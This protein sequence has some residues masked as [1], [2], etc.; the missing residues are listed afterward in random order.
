MKFK[1]YLAS[2]F[3]TFTILLIILLVL[4]IYPFGNKTLIVSDLRDQYMV[5]IDYIK[6][7][8][9]GNTLFYTFNSSLG[10]NFFLLSAYYLI[11]IFNLLTIF[12]DS[13]NMPLII[14]FIILI[15][16]SLSSVTMLYYLNNKFGNKKINYLFA[17][18]YGLMSYN[19]AFY[20]H[21]MWLDS[22][23]ILP[24]IILGI[25]KIFN[26]KSVGL[27]II[28]LSMAIISNYYIGVILCIFSVI[29]FIYYYFINI[30]N[31]KNVKKVIIKYILSS[32]IS[33]LMCAVI[34]L[35][36]FCSLSSS[37]AIVNDGSIVIS[38]PYSIFEVL[39]KFINSPFTVSQIWHG[40]PNIFTG[41]L[42]TVLSILYFM[43]NKIDKRKRIINFILVLFILLTFSIRPLDLVFHGLTE[44]N[45]FDYRHAFILS[46]ILIIIGYES[47]EKI[48][49][50]NRKN[51]V[52]A[53]ILLL[54]HIITYFMDYSW[55]TG[56]R[57]LF[58]IFSMISFI[59]CLFFIKK[60]N[61]KWLF[62]W[63][64]LDLFVNACNTIATIT[65]YE[66]DTSDL[67]SYNEYFLE[68]R[69]I[70]NDLKELDNSFYRM[71]KDYFHGNNINDSMVFNYFGIS[72]FDSTGTVSNEL[73]LEN[74]GFRHAVS[75][76][77]YG[78]GSTKGADMLFGIKYVLSHDDSFRDYKK[79]INKNGIN[80]YQNPYYIGNAYIVNNSSDILYTNDIFSN[81]NK[82]FNNLTNISDLYGK[83][84]YEVSYN[85]VTI[86]DNEYLGDKDS[87]IE[88]LIDIANNSDYYIHFPNNSITT[89]Y[90][91]ATI[92]IDYLKNDKVINSKVISKY[93][94]KY[95][96]GVIKLGNNGDKVR[97]RIYIDNP[98]KYLK[99]DDIYIYYE[100]NDKF[101]EIYNYL[102]DK[103]INLEFINSSNLKSEINLS[104]DSTILFTIPYDNNWHI[105]DNGK[106]INYDSI[107][108]NLIKIDL[109]KGNHIIT[110][111][112]EVKGLKLGS[113]ISLIS[114]L[115]VI[116]YL[117]YEKKKNRS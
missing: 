114:L 104:S 42:M 22:I 57:A 61:Y 16:I 95:N 60:K 55:F 19:M 79:I 7:L 33:G 84:K 101:M 38:Y 35:P 17:V 68:N 51:I 52:L 81:L 86:S 37:K 102:K 48:N 82:I 40:G 110:L 15:K 83:A 97:V 88:Y 36:V 12:S 53:S 25:E 77:Y 75:R 98:Y 30:K 65:I 90:P 87:Y 92:E 5:F 29:Y 11:S 70:I 49:L 1:R 32:L 50:N 113:I 93:F 2:F 66:K 71:E 112:Y 76:N 27:Y 45:C 14:T 43:N 8:F 24:L 9:N 115:T 20:F 94:E 18:S 116:S 34:I 23:I 80:V 73:F 99:Y 78:G 44:P 64:I 6:T 41:T 111:N 105:Y 108:N 96:Y 10:S 56:Y 109:E 100:D 31:I 26:N 62:I 89:K 106:E 63:V 72:H 58:L 85:N 74:I 117:I 4:G 59:L 46:F 13:A 3:L 28:S 67:T 91:S 21:I 47:L 54:F 107:I 39:T 69:E 103:N